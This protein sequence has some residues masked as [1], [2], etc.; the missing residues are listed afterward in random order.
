MEAEFE[1]LAQLK[2][3]L[4]EK[5]SQL[6]SQLSKLEESE[7]NN[8]KMSKIGEDEREKLQNQ[9]ITLQQHL[10]AQTP[11]NNVD[12]KKLILQV[13]NDRIGEIY[14][15][16]Q[17]EIDQRWDIKLKNLQNQINQL[18][19]HLQVRTLDN[20]DGGYIKTQI[21]IL[22]TEEQKL[23]KDYKDQEKRMTLS[24][25]AIMV[26]AKRESIDNS[27]LGVVKLFLKKELRG[28]YWILTQGSSQYLVPSDRLRINEFNIITLEQLFECQG[29]DREVFTHKFE[30]KFELLK[31]AKVFSIGE[32][33]WQ[34]EETGILWFVD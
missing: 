25:K 26:S 33:M 2:H 24:K 18:Q 16:L 14:R 7:I 9:I 19:Q 12:N 27:R 11:G 13:V 8:I 6:H 31:P 15:Q 17:Q 21:P 28:K 32:A 34:L 10:Q 1:R 23:L 20:V 4:S 3:E 30:P 5:L 22:L 29:V